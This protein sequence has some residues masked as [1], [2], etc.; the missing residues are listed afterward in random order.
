MH[1]GCQHAAQ[2]VVVGDEQIDTR[3]GGARELDRIGRAKP[4]PSAKVGIRSRGGAFEGDEN[5]APRQRL[6]VPTR[7]NRVA[8]FEGLHQNLPQGQC[9]C[10][11]LVSAIDHPLAKGDTIGPLSLPFEQID[12]QISSPRSLTRFRSRLADALSSRTPTVRI[13]VAPR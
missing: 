7:E 2:P 4:L 8:L 13:P 1:I 3:L 10:V 9:R 12:E 11:G 6:L 5:G